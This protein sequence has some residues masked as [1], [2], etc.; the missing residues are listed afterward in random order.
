MA[1]LSIRRNVNNVPVDEEVHK[2]LRKFKIHLANFTSIY[3]I[4]R[5]KGLVANP[6]VNFARINKVASGVEVF[7]IRTEDA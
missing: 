1:S 3:E 4:A 7:S 6:E 2:E 5:N